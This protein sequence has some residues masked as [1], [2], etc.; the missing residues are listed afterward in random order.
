MYGMEMWKKQMLDIRPVL[1]EDEGFYRVDTDDTATNYE[2]VWGYPTIH[3]FLSTVPAEIFRFYDGAAGI[4]RWV[5]SELNVD[6]EG[7]RALLSTR[8]YIWNSAIYED[9]EFGKGEGVYGFDDIVYE[10]NGLTVYENKNFIPPGFTFEYYIRESVFDEQNK[11]NMDRLLVKA[12]ILSDEDADTYGHLM[13]ELTAEDAVSFISDRSF[14]QQCAARRESACETFEV[15]ESGFYAVTKDLEKESLVFFSVPA[16]EGF[17]VT[18]DGVVTDIIEADY[19]LMAVHVPPGVHEIEARYAPAHL[20]TGAM[21]SVSGI[22]A[23]L[24]YGLIS[25]VAANKKKEKRETV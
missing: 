4:T 6:R 17:T 9:G 11:A 2:M 24:M 10:D 3:C 22:T 21:I 16:S 23:T 1:P 14:D 5:E 7:I 19:S 20:D 13:K 8:Y 15:R 12:L 25:M 18:L